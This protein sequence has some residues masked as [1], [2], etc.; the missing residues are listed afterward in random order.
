MKNNDAV[1][2]FYDA[3]VQTEWRR[4]EKHSAEFAITKHCLRHCIRPGD[5]GLDLGGGP[6]RYAL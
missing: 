1:R 2:A 5:R 6:G 3:G 4:L